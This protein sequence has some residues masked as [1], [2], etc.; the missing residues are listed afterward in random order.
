MGGRD[1]NVCDNV[2][3]QNVNFRSDLGTMRFVISN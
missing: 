1:I 3:V 2:G